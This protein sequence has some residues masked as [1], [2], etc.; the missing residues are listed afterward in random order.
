MASFRG[1]KDESLYLQISNRQLERLSEK[2]TTGSNV[3]RELKME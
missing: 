1:L 3:S 2:K